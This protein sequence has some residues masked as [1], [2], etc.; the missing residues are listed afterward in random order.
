MAGG[1]RFASGVGTHCIESPPRYS[2]P[3]CARSAPAL[4]AGHSIVYHCI[5]FST[6]AGVITWNLKSSAPMIVMRLQIPLPEGQQLLQTRGSIALSPAGT[7][8]LYVANRQLF[9][10]SMSETEARPIGDAN[11]NPANPFFS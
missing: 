11:L 5:V 8:L 10:R 4:E 7:H 1:R 6:T 3:S 2:C 9:L